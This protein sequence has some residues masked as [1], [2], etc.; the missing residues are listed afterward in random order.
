M[1]LITITAGVGTVFE[2]GSACLID[3]LWAAA[4][5]EDEVEHISVRAVRC[6]VDIGVFSVQMDQVTARA[7]ASNLVE[8]A[9]A[10]SPQLRKWS[11][12]AT[13]PG[14]VGS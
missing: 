11:V 10:M 6:R 7:V 14:I 5:A 3:T 8:R 2:G 9:L 13:M 1:T 12:A 4:R